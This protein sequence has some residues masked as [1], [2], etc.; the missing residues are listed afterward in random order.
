[1]IKNK[2]IGCYNSIFLNEVFIF[3]A[4]ATYFAPSAPM[5]LPRK[6]IFVNEVFTFNA[7]A[8]YFAPSGPMLLPRKKIYDNEVFAFGQG[9]I[10]AKLRWRGRAVQVSMRN[11]HFELFF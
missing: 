2:K 10:I 3:N 5:L 11:R 9:M 4:S 7:S 8:T 6:K 1:M